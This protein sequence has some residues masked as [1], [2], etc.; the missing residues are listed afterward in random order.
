M[1]EETV[2]VGSFEGG[3]S[4]EEFGV[5]GGVPHGEV[6]G[7]GEEDEGV[8]AGDAKDVESCCHG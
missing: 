6:T 8:I 4:V 1:A 7:L 2:P 3:P 5:E